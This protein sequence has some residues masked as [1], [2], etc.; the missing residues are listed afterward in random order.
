MMVF[1]LQISELNRGGSSHG[2]VL[3]VAG[4]LGQEH[5]VLEALA[6]LV[7]VRNQAAS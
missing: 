3:L 1:L 2:L 7:L 6:V 5:L 4:V